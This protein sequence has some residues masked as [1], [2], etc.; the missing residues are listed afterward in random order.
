MKTNI[1]MSKVQIFLFTLVLCLAVSCRKD[2]SEKEKEPVA[3]PEVE[4]VILN[5]RV[6][7][8]PEDMPA[9]TRAINN[10][11]DKVFGDL[12][13]I[14][15][16]WN[17][18]RYEYNTV[19]PMFKN[20]GV[21]DSYKVNLP[22]NLV[23]KNVKVGVCANSL[24][25]FTDDILK[26]LIAGM[27]EAQVTQNLV[28]SRNTR[29]NT[30]SGTD[31][32]KIPMYGATEIKPLETNTSS[33]PP[34][35]LVKMLARVDVGMN[36]TGNVEGSTA[37]KLANFNL[38][39]VWVYYSKD[40]GC[41]LF[42]SQTTPTMPASPHVVANITGYG[43]MVPSTAAAV[44]REIYLCEYDDNNNNIFSN[45]TVRP[46]ILVRGRYLYDSDN[47][48]TLESGFTGWYRLDFHDGANYMDIVRNHIYRFNI[49]E[50]RGIGT[51]KPED[52][53]NSVSANVLVTLESY[54]M[55]Q[56]DVLFDGQ[57][58][59][60]VST[61]S[62]VVYGDNAPNHMT[63]ETNHP[64]GWKIEIIPPGIA[65]D[66]E[67]NLKCFNPRSNPVGTKEM[68]FNYYT[69]IAATG[70]PWTM[71]FYVVAGNLKKRCKGMI[72]STPPPTPLEQFTVPAAIY[73]AKGGGSQTLT[74]N[75]NLANAA[76][77]LR[78]STLLTASLGRAQPLSVPVTVGAAKTAP[79]TANGGTVSTPIEIS[80]SS[81]STN[82]GTKTQVIQ[83]LKDLTGTSKIFGNPTATIG[84]N[85]TEFPMQASITD[86]YPY[87]HECQAVAPIAFASRFLQFDPTNTSD[88]NRS[89]VRGLPINDMSYAERDIANVITHPASKQVASWGGTAVVDGDAAEK[90]KINVANG[91]NTFFTPRVLVVKQS[92]KPKPDYKPNESIF[93]NVQW[94]WNT[95]GNQGVTFTKQANSGDASEVTSYNMQF[96][97]GKAGD[98]DMLSNYT[99]GGNTIS[100]GNGGGA[101]KILQ[102]TAT[103][104][105]TGAARVVSANT[106]LV[107]FG[108]IVSLYTDPRPLKITQGAPPSPSS[109]SLTVTTSVTGS[110]AVVGDDKNFFTGIYMRKYDINIPS[111]ASDVTVNIA[112]LANAKIMR[113]AR[114]LSTP[115]VG[116][117]AN[118]SHWKSLG[119]TS[120]LT[121]VPAGG[122]ANTQ[123]TSCSFIFQAAANPLNQQRN[124]AYRVDLD[125]YNMDITTAAGNAASANR[126]L[127]F[128]FIQP[129]SPTLDLQIEQVFGSGVFNPGDKVHGTVPAR[130]Y[131]GTKVRVVSN[132]NWRAT[133]EGTGAR[134]NKTNGGPNEEI[135][136]NM[137]QNPVG[138][139]NYREA[140]LTVTLND[141]GISKTVK[142]RQDQGAPANYVNRILYTNGNNNYFV[143]NKAGTNEEANGTGILYTWTNAVNKC[144][145]VF[146]GTLIT[147]NDAILLIQD[148][149]NF[150]EGGSPKGNYELTISRYI[151]YWTS[152]IASPSS[153]WTI[154]IE[155]VGPFTIG[156]GSA[157]SSNTDTNS[158]IKVRCI[159]SAPKTPPL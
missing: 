58:Y 144:K 121:T 154:A 56:N 112:N 57:H 24:A 41:L 72:Y 117:G 27:T 130:D 64:D 145:N 91:P 85:A 158:N 88:G 152:T 68:A 31:Y 37:Q 13:A 18:N 151:Q 129:A 9:E 45:G 83:F 28:L 153:K 116:V 96:F 106:W 14:I 77:V 157:Q 12:T 52:A 110:T 4:D 21:N 54:K 47:N 11:D 1:A 132:G 125:P 159:K 23:N 124:A 104:N 81:G 33:L 86:G 101:S 75:T 2:K 73:Y 80:L 71:N 143:S 20:E 42:N 119:I 61:D 120:V 95:V 123:A 34:V 149:Q 8:A 141:G 98:L 90:L 137:D 148:A 79:T 30:T 15:F 122:D 127:L 44:E 16:I 49:K 39:E 50:V 82:V 147:Q 94:A 35:S 74:V 92:G 43:I 60:S 135:L 97:P 69:N 114:I 139:A 22:A 150:P 36:Y 146:G 93:G 3:P 87:V 67:N 32:D 155:G 53:L 78:P 5:L 55:G 134:I 65:T 109:A 126:I 108:D 6:L 105:R 66:N 115:I 26:R 113:P 25:I 59:L 10:G 51:I 48:G 100:G 70:G 62:L 63:I 38:D 102:L 40:K 133:I 136:I 19:R 107:G 76:F 103:M 142:V 17:N 99:S 29:W 7:G 89:T 128:N 111:G 131:P 84:W 46:C 138:S 140:T 118:E 156:L